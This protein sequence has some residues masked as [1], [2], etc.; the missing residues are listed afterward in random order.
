MTEASFF[1]HSHKVFSDEAARSDARQRLEWLSWAMD[2]AVRVPGTSITL[3]ADAVLGLVPGIGNLASTAISGYVIRE[4]WRLGV[5]RRTLARMVGN[6]ALDSLISAVPL[7]GNF[8]DVFW[9]A[10]RKN[11]AILADHLGHDRRT[12]PRTIDGDWRRVR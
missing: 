7:V 3:G 12:A 2:S 1:S 9:K 11:M 5:P 8:A 10:N 4:A 6:V